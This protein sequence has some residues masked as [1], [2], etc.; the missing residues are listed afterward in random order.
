MSLSAVSPSDDEVAQS[1]CW[2]EPVEETSEWNTGA[3][4]SSLN[5]WAPASTASPSSLSFTCGSFLYLQQS[6]LEN[7]NVVVLLFLPSS[8]ILHT[9]SF[10]DGMDLCD[11]SPHG[12]I[13]ASYMSTEIWQVC[14]L[15]SKYFFGKTS[16]L[17]S[18]NS[19]LLHSYVFLTK[20]L[21]SLLHLI[22]DFAVCL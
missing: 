19:H 1:R 15:H 3:H 11:C 12:K 20:T 7:F 16:F 22:C 10:P 5:F 14:S 8:L 2:G 6:F 9:D 4:Q 13:F 17:A 21:K 18:S